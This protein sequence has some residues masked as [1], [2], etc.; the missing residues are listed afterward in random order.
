MLPLLV[1]VGVGEVSVGAAR[2]GAVRGWVR[3][4][5]LTQTQRLARAALEAPSATA[6]ADLAAPTAEALRLLDEAGD[7]A[8]ESVEGGA[9]VVSVGPQA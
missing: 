7:A 2:V 9:G 6:V 4:L 3:A 5:E 8:G 1:G